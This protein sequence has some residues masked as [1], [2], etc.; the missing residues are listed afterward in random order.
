M[1]Q[2]EVRVYVVWMQKIKR[3]RNLLTIERSQSN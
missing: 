2:R 3:E 1:T